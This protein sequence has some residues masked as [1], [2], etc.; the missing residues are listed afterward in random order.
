MS[1]NTTL[2]IKYAKRTDM[3]CVSPRYHL[4]FSPDPGYSIRKSRDAVIQHILQHRQVFG[5]S[6]RKGPLKL[7]LN[8]RHR[9][10]LKRVARKKRND[11]EC[12]GSPEAGAGDFD[13]VLFNCFFNLSLLILF[14]SETFFNSLY[15]LIIAS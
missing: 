14:I 13:F 2:W 9:R 12:K 1:Q 8:E 15:F 5:N 7:R 11:A 10:H 3:K 4:L 6:F